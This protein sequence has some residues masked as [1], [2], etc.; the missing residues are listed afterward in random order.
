MQ[1]NSKRKLTQAQLSN[2]RAPVNLFFCR[3]LE[4]FKKKQDSSL[5]LANRAAVQVVP[6][7]FVWSEQVQR[8]ITSA[9]STNQRTFTGNHLIWICLACLIFLIIQPQSNTSDILHLTPLSAA[10]VRA[11]PTMSRRYA[12][13]C[14]ATSSMEQH[15]FHPGAENVLGVPTRFVRNPRVQSAGDLR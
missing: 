4:S 2:S 7:I 3:D 14:A 11:G 6:S 12:A 8:Q 9:K 10:K 1:T 15:R 13:F 5:K